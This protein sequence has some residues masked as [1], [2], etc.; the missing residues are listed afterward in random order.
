MTAQINELGHRTS[1]AY[2]DAGRQTAVTNALGA[3]NQ[4]AYEAAGRKTSET[5]ALGHTTQFV[6]DELGRRT[7]T[8]FADGTKKSTVYDSLGRVV[9]EIDQGE[10]T[11]RFEYDANGRL[12]AVVDALTHRTEYG[13]NEA[14]SLVL[15]RDANGHETRYE[16][17]TC[18]Q[19][20]ATILPMGQRS[21]TQ[22]NPVG[23]VATVTNFNGQVITYDYDV[24]NRLVRKTLNSQSLN[25]QPITYT[26][27]PTGRRETITDARGVT[28][29]AYDPRDRL[30]SRTD[31]D[32]RK[33]QYGYD[34][35]GNRTSLTIPSGPQLFSFDELNR[36]ATVTDA[37]GGITRYTYDAA[38]NVRRMDYPNGTVRT[39]VYDQLNRLTY[40]E[41]R[42]PSGVF[43][44]FNYTLAPTGNRIAFK[45]QDGRRVHYGYDGLSRLTKEAI[46][47][48]GVTNR[49]I[50]YVLDSVGNRLS[51]DDSAEGLTAYSYDNNDELL[52]ETLGSLV[53]RYTY[54]AN[55]NTL[56]RSNATESVEYDWN[57]ENRLTD[58][59]R[60]DSGQLPLATGHY[61]YDDDGIRVASIANAV[62]TRYLID[63]NRPFAEALEEYAPDGTV[64]T[65]YLYGQNLIYQNR[66][67]ARSYYHGDHLNSTRILTG[68]A[69]TPTDQ[70]QYDA[71]GRIVRQN[72]ATDNAYLFTGEQRDKQLGLDYLRARYLSGGAGRFCSR[73]HDGGVAVQPVTLNQFIYAAADPVNKLDPTGE[74]FLY[75]QT[76]V[77]LALYPDA[78]KPYADQSTVYYNWF[79]RRGIFQYVFLQAHTVQSPFWYRHLSLKIVPKNQM[80]WLTAR[81]S[82]FMPNVDRFGNHFATIGAGPD[83]WAGPFGKL[84]RGINRDRDVR[85]PKLFLYPL[86]EGSY[87]NQD[88]L[89]EALFRL[90]ANYGNNL[91]YTTFPEGCEGYNSNSYIS[92]LLDAAGV[93]LP[94]IIFLYDL[95][96][97]GKPVPRSN[98]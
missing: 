88:E 3:V 36:L 2:D 14:G 64:N 96:G 67:G 58:F 31:P 66:A 7:Q 28:R 73:D 54:D 83:S 94:S 1:F 33:I 92:G 79:R 82:D 38:N 55:G 5:D 80:K 29:F 65:T 76:V 10:N 40:I 35:A 57:A 9:A 70:Y 59:R 74:F 60:F 77:A 72:G 97:V 24:N 20:G 32:G 69:G 52:T 16:Y 95:P 53:T 30:L 17:I 15:Q 43:A 61:S 27:T 93:S 6:Y 90:N 37:A 62:E 44:S 63:A 49:T 46:V 19:R 25:P 75:I 21:S 48:N 78:V 18:C 42:G 91:E 4:S 34:A 11:N 56:S 51:R 13:Y 47:E 22:Y 50:A 39:N 71:Y 81:P 12:T 8:L 89:I 84:A 86:S 26:Y 45:E 68:S 23:N 98:F 41:H 87:L 85:E